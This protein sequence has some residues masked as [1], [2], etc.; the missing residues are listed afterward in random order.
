VNVILFMSFA[1]G[2]VFACF[3]PHFHQLMITDSG[4]FI[5]ARKNAERELGISHGWSD[6]LPLLVIRFPPH[7]FKSPVYLLRQHQAHDLVRQGEPAEAELA[8]G[9]AQHVAA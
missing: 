6:C 7:D 8:V 1:F 4:D 3:F 9:A 2:G 5:P